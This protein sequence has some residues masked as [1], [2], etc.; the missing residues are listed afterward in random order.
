MVVV[1]LVLT[2][3][4]FGFR[5]TSSSADLCGAVKESRQKLENKNLRCHCEQNNQETDGV[6]CG[7]EPRPLWI[8]HSQS[9]SFIG[10]GQHWVEIL[11]LMTCNSQQRE[12]QKAR[13]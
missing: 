11:Q 10:G 7:A 8:T 5:A 4:S 6:H 3:N 1:A 9:S 2:K 13:R 12:Y